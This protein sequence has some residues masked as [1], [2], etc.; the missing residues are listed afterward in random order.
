[1]VCSTANPPTWL[2]CYH[3]SREWSAL[4][5]L[6]NIGKLW[7]AEQWELHHW[8]DGLFTLA[9]ST[10]DAGWL[11]AE[12]TKITTLKYLLFHRRRK[13]IEAIKEGAARS[14]KPM[15]MLICDDAWE[16]MG[17]TEQLQNCWSICMIC[18]ICF[19][20]WHTSA[21]IIPY[22]ITSHQQLVALLTNI[23]R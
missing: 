18:S 3:W 11:W 4:C 16:K 15:I 14:V 5:S 9:F 19:W 23:K 1:M 10:C 13:T 20:E 12:K 6:W 2:C 17:V 22:Q 8:P 7:W 21:A